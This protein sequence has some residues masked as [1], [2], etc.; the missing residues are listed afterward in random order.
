MKHRRMKS[1]E[2]I[3][4]HMKEIYLKF[5]EESYKDNGGLDLKTKELIAIAASLAAKCENCLKG[6]IKKAIKA[7]ATRQEVSEAVVIAVG[8]NAAAIVDQTDIANFD[9]DILKMF[10]ENEKNTSQK[11]PD[12]NS[13]D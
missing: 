7:G 12:A 8:I 1:Y 4:E 3:D 10:E 5:Y 2:L 11:N 13:S 9:M 6:H